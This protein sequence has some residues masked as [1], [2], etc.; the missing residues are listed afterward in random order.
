MPPSVETNDDTTSPSKFLR[1]RRHR[2][3]DLC[4]RHEQSPAR[5]EFARLQIT[6]ARLEVVLVDE[7]FPSCRL[8]LCR[9]LHLQSWLMIGDPTHVTSQPVV[10]VVFARPGEVRHRESFV[11]P[12]VNLLRGKSF[13]VKYEQGD[14]VS[15]PC[16]ELT[17]SIGRKDGMVR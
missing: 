12:T 5:Q 7:N 1:R 16:L 6:E 8:S 14:I 2:P 10:L 11:D 15:R 9:S 17:G 3:T 4:A 13:I